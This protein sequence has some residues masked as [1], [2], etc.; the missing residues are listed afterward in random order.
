MRISWFGA[1][2]LLL[3]LSRVFRGKFV[4][5]LR[6][7]FRRQKLAFHRSCVSLAQEKAFKSFLRSLHRQEWVVYAK[8]RSVGR[9][10]CCST[11][12]AT[13]ISVAISNH[14]LLS[15]DDKQVRRWKDY[16]HDNK[17]RV[18][19]LSDE[20]FLRRFFNTCFRKGSR[21]SAIWLAH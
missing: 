8:P 3:V 13:P 6:N 10:T 20:E 17:P 19:T 16:A 18:M 15:V 5:G 4:D 9:N 11:W 7:K 14:R 12:H 2:S 1:R 21:A